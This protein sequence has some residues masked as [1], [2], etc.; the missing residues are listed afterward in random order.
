MRFRKR[1]VEVE[2]W[3]FPG[4]AN[5]KGDP[6]IDAPDWVRLDER[7]TYSYLAGGPRLRGRLFIKTLEGEMAADAGDWIVRGIKG[8]LYPVK[9]DIF[10]ET[11]ELIEPSPPAEPAPDG[12]ATLLSDDDAQLV[13]DEKLLA[14]GEG[15]PSACQGSALPDERETDDQPTRPSP[16]LLINF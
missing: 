11:Y 1:P 13:T 6:L 2:A 3:E 9:P 10:A 4:A 12:G 15:V 7:V 5:G 14:M 16:R 8:E